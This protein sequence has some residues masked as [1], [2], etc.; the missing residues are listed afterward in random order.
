MVRPRPPSDL[1]RG[2]L[3][4]QAFEAAAAVLHYLAW[5]HLNAGRAIGASRFIHQRVV[6][7][8]Q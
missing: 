4:E 3:H 2:L 5:F 7:T 1:S 8:S 6:R